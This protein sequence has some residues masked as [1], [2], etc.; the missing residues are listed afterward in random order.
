MYDDDSDWPA[1]DGYIYDTNDK[2]VN[3]RLPPCF[4]ASKYIN[5]M[6][7]IRD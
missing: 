5:K 6:N 7:D 4:Y 3:V 2:D 1:S